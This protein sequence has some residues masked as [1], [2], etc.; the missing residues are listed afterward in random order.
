MK[1]MQKISGIAGALVITAGMVAGF[2]TNAEAA[3]PAGSVETRSVAVSYADLDLNRGAGVQALYQRLR[4]A[5]KRACGSYDTRDRIG[6]ASVQAC[7]EAAL[8]DAVARLG[9]E[10]VAWF[11]SAGGRGAKAPRQRIAVRD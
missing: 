5:A 11:H 4:V 1:T 6:R 2:A 9:N 8:T 10:R 3:P 7:R